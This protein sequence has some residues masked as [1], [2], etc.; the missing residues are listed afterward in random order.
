MTSKIDQRTRWDLDANARYA[1]T[2][3][4]CGFEYALTQI[5]FMAGY[6]AVKFPQSLRLALLK[7]S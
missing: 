2:A 5:R 4:H 6:G 3:E 7:V 1:Q